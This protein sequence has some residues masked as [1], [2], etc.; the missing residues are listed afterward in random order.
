[1]VKNQSKKRGKI[2]TQQKDNAIK[3]KQIAEK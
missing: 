3:Y 1:M 2:L